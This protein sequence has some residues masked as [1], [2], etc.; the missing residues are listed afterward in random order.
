M[1]ESRKIFAK[2]VSLNIMGM[3][4]LSCYILADTFFVANGVGAD[5]LTALNLAIPIYSF[6]NGSGLMIGIGGSTKYSILK[7]EKKPYEANQ[8]FTQ[9]LYLGILLSCIF[10]IIGFMFS[11]NLT[12]LLGADQTVFDMTHT[13]IKIMLFFSP[14]FICNNIVICFVRND[15]NPALSMLATATGSFTNIILDYIFIFPCQMGIFGA[16]IATG[17]APIVGLL[18]SSRHFIVRRKTFHH[19]WECVHPVKAAP[20]FHS[21]VSICSLG[22]SSLITELASGIVMIV[23]NLIILSLSGN[24]G[25]AAYGI[26]ANLSLVVTSIFTGIAQGIQPIVSH[27]HG[28]GDTA[29]IR[30]YFRY[31]LTLSTG[32]ALGIYLIVTFGHIPLIGAFN[33]TNNLE[34]FQIAEKGI[35]LYFTAFLFVGMNIISASLFGAVNRPIPA[36][37]LSIMRGFVVIIPVVFAMSTLLGMTGVW[38]S[39]PVTELLT[40][41]VAGYLMWKFFIKLSTDSISK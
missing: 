41:V 5:G 12:L 14:A 28:E 38:L 6:I 2:Y 4:A 20:S 29:T 17:F 21:W 3:I 40:S 24:V 32:L 31:A 37:T 1:K 11:T 30:T 8:A 33:D 27:A 25:V 15:G 36:F 16:V 34:L 19:D 39:F 26:I 18:I 22:V 35:Y 23:F 10:L 7:A 13:Y 9:T